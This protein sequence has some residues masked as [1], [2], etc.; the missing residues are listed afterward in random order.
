[1]QRKNSILKARSGIAMIMAIVVIV[2]LG[3]IMAL[4]LN[5]SAQTN[6]QTINDYIHEQGILLTRSA[7]EYALLEI[8]GWPA[9]TVT[10]LSAVYPS[11]DT[12]KI[13][14]INIS[15]NYI[16]FGCG[17]IDGNG[18]SDDYI[19]NINTPESRGTVLM[20]VIVTSSNEL[21]LSEPIRYHRR[22]MQK[23]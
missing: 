21:N 5:M 1:M 3:T 4:T 11:N 6:K 10:N 22:T 19:A 14:D 20:D 9:C 12:A 13:F 2:V 16:G 23:L 17:D 8:S 7:T 18:Q 15:V